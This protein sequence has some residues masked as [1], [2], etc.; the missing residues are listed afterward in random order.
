MCPQ[1]SLAFDS[2]LKIA[3]KHGLGVD[4]VS[5]HVG[6]GHRDLTRHEM[7]LSDTRALFYLVGA[8]EYGLK[9]CILDVEGGFP[10]ET[11]SLWN[12]A[13]IFGDPTAPAFGENKT[14]SQRQR[15]Y[16]IDEQNRR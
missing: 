14:S 9:I 12:P 13:D 11:H 5:F 15:Q 2:L 7:V 6:S 10:G 1:G 8:E 16:T 4:G 3:K